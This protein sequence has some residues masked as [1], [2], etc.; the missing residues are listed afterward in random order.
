MP[1][2]PPSRAYSGRILASHPPAIADRSRRRARNP[3]SAPRRHWTP[4]PAG[5]VHFVSRRPINRGFRI[6]RLFPAKMPRRMSEEQPESPTESR[7]AGTTAA[8]IGIATA[9]TV[10]VL[11]GW[12]LH[13]EPMKRIAPGL[14]SMNPLTATGFLLASTAL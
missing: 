1:R 13:V 4:D 12:T 8:L 10:I 7:H 11:L 6:R 14:T 2:R 5:P 9:I 3:A